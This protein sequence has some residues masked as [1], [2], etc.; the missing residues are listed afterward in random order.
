MDH[1]A[2]NYRFE[3]KQLLRYKSTFGS[4]KQIV[5]KNAVIFEKLV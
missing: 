3:I 5:R 1:P 2:Q 4:I